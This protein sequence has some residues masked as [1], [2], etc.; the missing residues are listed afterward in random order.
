MDVRCER[1]ATV[2]DFDESRVPPE[3]LSV[4]CSACGY[5]F[6]AYRPSAAAGAGAGASWMVRQHTSGKV[7]RFKEMTT[8]Q[9]WIVERKVARDDGI[10]KNGSTWRRL[11]DITELTPFFR[12]VD[13]PQ[14]APT[15][16]VSTPVG[17]PQQAGYPSA[18]P[19]S[20]EWEDELPKSAKGKW[21]AI[22]AVLALA[23]A[24]VGVYVYRPSFVERLLPGSVDPQATVELQQGYAALM[25]DSFAAISE[26]RAHFEKALALAPDFALAKA[27][28]AQ[29]D[30][31]RAEYLAEEAEEMSKRL[32]SLPVPDQQ[33]LL[34]EIDKHRREFQLLTQRAFSLAK[35]ALTTLPHAAETN[36]V[37]ADYYRVMKAPDT[38]K[39]LIERARQAAPNDPAVAYLQGASAA[40]DA[41]LAERA[42]RYFDEALEAAPNLQR[43]R[44]KLAQVFFAQ[45]NRDK[46]RLHAQTVLQAVPDHERAKSLLQQIDPPEPVVEAAADAPT[47]EADAAAATGVEASDNA[48]APGESETEKPEKK[49]QTYEQVIAAA[50]RL[51]QSD[52]AR[53]ALKFYER[54]AEME[55][56]DPDAQTGIGWCY[57]DLEEPAFAISSFKRA[58]TLAP[59]LTDAHMGLAEAYRMKGMKRDAIKHYREYLDILPSGPEAQVAR[60]MIEQLS[61]GAPQ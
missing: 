40:T 53:R 10:S 25:R 42:I 15:T 38:A 52:Q 37:M 14:V 45:G 39:P 24:A 55:P 33:G 30:L 29:A 27:A 49:E 57:I 5:A 17:M 18:T 4:K 26:G 44:Y 47:E 61:Q 31:N 46:A 1:C 12:V 21:I 54:A 11:G 20:P 2:Y 59:R 13:A 35:E 58:L 50:E 56:D 19:T 51:R 48:A 9:R 6:R 7:V 32:A 43:A 8:L 28:I 16:L 36:R 22:V 34:P 3:G 41:K 23:A 60:R